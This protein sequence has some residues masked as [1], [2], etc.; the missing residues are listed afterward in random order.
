MNAYEVEFT[1][2]LH[3]EA[4][5]DDEAYDRAEVLAREAAAAGQWNNYDDCVRPISKEEF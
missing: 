2:V 4:S 1:V 3:I 5:S